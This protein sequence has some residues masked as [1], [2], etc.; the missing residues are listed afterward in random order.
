[1]TAT[2]SQ[3]Q[4]TILIIGA[5]LGGLAAAYYFAHEGH[6]V[7]SGQQVARHVNEDFSGFPDWGI[8]RKTT[9]EILYKSATARGAEIRFGREAVGVDEDQRH[10]SVLFSDGSSST[11]DMV[12][13]ADGIGST[14]RSRI[15]G[16]G[17][18]ARPIVT[19]ATNF[20][21]ELEYQD[22]V[23]SGLHQELASFSD[24]V[25]WIGQDRYAIGRYVS[26]LGKVFL[27]FDI[28]N[29]PAPAEDHKLW[30]E[31]CIHMRPGESLVD[32][33]CLDWGPRL[34]PEVLRRL[35]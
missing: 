33:I 32:L 25:V 1:M 10:A 16:D 24:G 4:L 35:L 8:D 28:R 18:K 22:I 7:K 12:L 26:K 13:V 31:V 9:Q 30:Q 27:V 19:N 20:T 14:F 17:G 6:H 3:A 2:D 34:R 29:G 15:L 11:G 21:L 23:E 5:G